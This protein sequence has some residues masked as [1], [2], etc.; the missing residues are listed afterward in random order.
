M[1][2]NEDAVSRSNKRRR[3]GRGRGGGPSPRLI[4]SQSSPSDS[5]KLD[6]QGTVRSIPSAPPS[7]LLWRHGLVSAVVFVV[8]VGVGVG[9]VLVVRDFAALVSSVAALCMALVILARPRLPYHGFACLVVAIL[10]VVTSDSAIN[11]LVARARE[12]DAA[13]VKASLDQVEQ[14]LAT[15]RQDQARDSALARQENQSL[16]D[17][18]D[19]ASA[20][21]DSLATW[22][23]G[24]P[25]AVV[26]LI[27]TTNKPSP[28]VLGAFT[29]GK[30]AVTGCPQTENA[31]PF[32]TIAVSVDRTTLSV[33]DSV[34]IVVTVRNNSSG[35][36]DI[37]PDPLVTRP[38][39]DLPEYF[40]PFSV[41]PTVVT[42]VQPG[43]TVALPSVL[44][45]LDYAGT[46]R[47]FGAAATSTQPYRSQ[48]EQAW[49][50]WYVSCPV[51]VTAR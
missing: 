2:T 12:A 44:M 45:R 39:T 33:A 26:D 1:A 16:Q 7:R 38:T 19:K 42:T 25:Q 47:V 28:D 15:S 43:Q 32:R 6:G 18:F 10:V 23:H 21:S 46:Y 34:N 35:N 17:R 50:N 51:L 20:A 31:A 40:S 37:T 49:Y 4:D 36:L 22:L 27:L 30:G 13:R 9:P 8:L 41:S 14:D 24:L 29:T 11:V 5:A 3:G 48:S